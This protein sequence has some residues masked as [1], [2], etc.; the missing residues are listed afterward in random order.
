MARRAPKRVGATAAGRGAVGLSPKARNGLRSCR[1]SCDP[2][3][4][5]PQP[6]V[7]EKLVKN[8]FNDLTGSSTTS[9][10]TGR[11]RSDYRPGNSPVVSTTNP[12]IAADWRL[13]TDERI[14]HYHRRCYHHGGARTP[15]SWRSSS[16]CR[17]CWFA[18]VS[19]NEKG[20]LSRFLTNSIGGSGD[21]PYP[22]VGA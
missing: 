4:R 16:E 21:C 3:T 2:W 22:A 5:A 15:V 20:C 12:R 1:M 8:I 10:S 19:S 13:P 18:I 7:T 6:P 17:C 9:L 11:S 14:H